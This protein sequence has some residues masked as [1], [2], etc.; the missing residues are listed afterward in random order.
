MPE[1]WK[2]I[3]SSSLQRFW[4]EHISCSKTSAEKEQ[5]LQFSAQNLLSFLSLSLSFHQ[6]ADFGYFLQEANLMSYFLP[7]KEILTSGLLPICVE[8]HD[9][10][11]CSLTLS[12]W[13]ALICIWKKIVQSKLYN[14]LL[15]SLLSYFFLYCV[16]RHICLLLSGHLFSILLVTIFFNT[17][18]SDALLINTELTLIFF[19]SFT[20]AVTVILRKNIKLRK[21]THLMFNHDWWLQN[22]AFVCQ[23]FV[24]LVL[25]PGNCSYW[26]WRD[27]FRCPKPW[28][29]LRYF[30]S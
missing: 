20:S 24:A 15:A 13:N 10:H 11:I 17:E 3:H 9:G 14:N 4:I 16:Y 6:K 25:T 18:C 28:Y 19:T 30:V 26:V 21:A 12:L 8:Q 1:G 29:F 7:I 22:W 23:Y 27:I 5:S 2:N